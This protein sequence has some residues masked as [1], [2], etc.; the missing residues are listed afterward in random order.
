MLTTHGLIYVLSDSARV[1]SAF[2]D[3]GVTSRQRLTCE[4][5]YGL[6]KVCP[7]ARCDRAGSASRTGLCSLWALFQRL[8]RTGAPLG[9]PERGGRSVET[10]ANG[11]R[12]STPGP[13]HI[14]AAAEWSGSTPTPS[15]ADRV[16]HLHATTRNAGTRRTI[17]ASSGTLAS[18]YAADPDGATTSRAIEPPDARRVIGPTAA[19]AQQHPDGGRPR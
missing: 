18:R 5:V 2:A 17:A 12:R 15:A 4:N 8:Q 9:R 14:T 7:D 19:P 13:S 6:P 1:G 16:L 10:G 11:Q 3:G